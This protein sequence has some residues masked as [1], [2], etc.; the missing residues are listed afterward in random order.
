[1]AGVLA[2]AH[3]ADSARSVLLRA[4]AGAD[5]DPNHDLTYV[6]ARVR[7]MLGDYDEAVELLRSLF[8]G[9]EAGGGGGD[10]ATWATHWWWNDLREHPGFKRLVEASR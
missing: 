6:E 9:F 8:G 10:A 7:T 5:V 4:R 2:R 3:E 1:V